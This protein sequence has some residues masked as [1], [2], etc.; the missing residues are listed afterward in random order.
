MMSSL[1]ARLFVG[2]AAFILMTGLAAGA[3]TFSWAFDEAIE[4]QLDHIKLDLDHTP[5]RDVH[6]HRRYLPCGKTITPRMPIFPGVG[7]NVILR[8][9]PN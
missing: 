4:L 5:T 6:S 7:L 2:L 3:I 1:R 9:Q 8:W